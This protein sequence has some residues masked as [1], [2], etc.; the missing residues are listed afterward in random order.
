MTRNSKFKSK[1]TLHNKN[2]NPFSFGY[3]CL[4][5]RSHLNVCMIGDHTHVYGWFSIAH[6]I[7]LINSTFVRGTLGEVSVMKSGQA[8]RR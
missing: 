6:P 8:M 2:T 3:I 5:L 7:S 4:P 1:N